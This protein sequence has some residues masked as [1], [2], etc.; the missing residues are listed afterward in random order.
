M[1]GTNTW[2]EITRRSPERG[3]RLYFPTGSGT[4]DFYGADRIGAKPVRR[5]ACIGARCAHGRAASAHF[6]NVHHDLWD[7]DNTLGSA[8]DEHQEGRKVDPRRGDGGKDRLPLC[9]QSG[10]GRAN[11]A[12]RGAARCRPRPKCPANRSGRRSRSPRARRRSPGRS[13]GPTMSIRAPDHAGRAASSSSS[14][15]Q[16]PGTRRPL[17]A[18][19]IRPTRST[20]LATT[21]DRTSAAPPRIRTTARFY[22]ISYDIPAIIR[23]LTPEEAAAR[24]QG[25]AA[26]AQA[27]RR[28]RDSRC[29]SATAR[30]ATEPIGAGTPNGASLVG[31]AGRLAPE[32]IRSTVTNGKGR[33]PPFP[34]LSAR[35]RSTPSSRTRRG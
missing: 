5:I 33:M 32:E 14:G 29:S 26:E 31:V 2:G 15:L 22:V 25:A 28:V 24:V 8:A 30:S 9:L 34:H 13:S 35:G 18:D 21:E 1:G 23:L 12:D 4:F 3:N 10:D 17:H 27:R 19:W 16:R 7:Y 20:C 11:L 6:Q